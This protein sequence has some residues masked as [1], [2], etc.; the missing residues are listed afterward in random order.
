MFLERLLGLSLT[1]AQVG[2]GVAFVE[3]VIE[4]AGEDG[5]SRLW[6]SAQA[7][8]TPA[9]VDAPGLWLARLEV[10]ENPS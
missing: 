1:R 8:P 4:R 3:G 9:E 2:R 5:L 6:T 7:L 10:D